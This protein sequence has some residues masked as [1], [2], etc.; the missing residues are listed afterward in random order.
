MIEFSALNSSYV[1]SYEQ[2]H[3]KTGVCMSVSAMIEI[4]Y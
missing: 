1:Q 4:K 3:A 2:N